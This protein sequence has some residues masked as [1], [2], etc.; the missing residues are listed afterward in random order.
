MSF[1]TA[2]RLTELVMA[3]AFVQQSLEHVFGSKDIR[4]LHLLR[5]ILGLFVLSGMFVTPSLLALM[6]LSL[7]ML[8]QYNGPYNGGSDR[9]SLLVLWLIGLVHLV[10][11]SRWQE[12]LLGYLALQVCLSYFISGKVKLVNAEWR[13][14]Q[15]LCDVFA[16]STYPVAENLR[17]FA[18]RQSLMLAMSWGVM[19]FEVLFPLALLDAQ[20][21]LGALIVAGTFHLANAMLFGL[22]RFFWI[23]LASYPS[24]IW[25]QERLLG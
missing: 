22:N 21:L 2:L 18:R 15:A 24:L 9:M 12:Y 14:G 17:G 23:W 16:F 10:P 8:Y 5:I 4:S 20:I 1:E 3:V 25:L 13:D 11:N 19:G 7:I 6:G